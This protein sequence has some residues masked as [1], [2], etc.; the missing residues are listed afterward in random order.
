MYPIKFLKGVFRLLAG[1]LAVRQQAASTGRSTCQAACCTALAALA[2]TA[3]LFCAQPINAAETVTDYWPSLNIEGHLGPIRA[4]TFTH[5][6]NYL[7]TGGGHL[8]QVWKLP[9]QPGQLAHYTTL[10]WEKA[11]DEWGNVYALAAK[12][13]EKSGAPLIAIAGHSYRSEMDAIAWFEIRQNGAKE[14]RGLQ[15]G[16]L[17]RHPEA[18]NGAKDPFEAVNSLACDPEGR[19]LVSLNRWGTAKVWNAAPVGNSMQAAKTISLR[20]P[21]ESASP[22]YHVAAARNSFVG[23]RLYRKNWLLQVHHLDAPKQDYSLGLEAQAVPRCIAIS[24]D[25]VY[26]AAGSFLPHEQKRGSVLVWQRGQTKPAHLALPQ[27]PQP[28]AMCFNRAGDMLVVGYQT[29]DGKGLFAA[30]HNENGPWTLQWSVATAA[31]VTACAL[32]PSDH[33]LALAIGDYEFELRDLRAPQAALDTRH[34]GQPATTAVAFSGNPGEYKARFHAEGGATW[35]FDPAPAADPKQPP[36]LNKLEGNGQF[37]L[38]SALQLDTTQLSAGRLTLAAGAAHF[39]VVPW[40][41]EYGRPTCACPMGGANLVAI[42]TAEKNRI[43]IFR[44]ASAN[45]AFVEARRFAGHENSVTSVDASADGKFLVSSSLDGTIRYWSLVHINSDNPHMQRWGAR[46]D[47]AAGAVL[48]SQVELSGPLAK[49]NVTPKSTIRSIE[50]MGDQAGRL[51]SNPQQILAAL[52][53][54]AKRSFIFRFETIDAAGKAVVPFYIRSDWPSILAV[55]QHSANPNAPEWIAWTHFGYFT[56]SPNGDQLLGWQLNYVEPESQPTFHLGSEL[57]E[58]YFQPALI[59]EWFLAAKEPIQVI[60]P[61]ARPV[62]EPAPVAKLAK[63]LVNKVR[64]TIK[65]LNPGVFAGVKDQRVALKWQLEGFDAPVEEAKLYV[66]DVN[67]EGSRGVSVDFEPAQRNFQQEFPLP[68]PGN[69]IVSAAVKVDGIW[70]DSDD[71]GDVWTVAVK[72]ESFPT[73][74]VRAIGCSRYHNR[75][76]APLVHSAEEVK[77]VVAQLA[78]RAAG[79][80]KL[81]Q[82]S[83]KQPAE[84]APW[85]SVE[86]LGFHIRQELDNLKADLNDANKDDVALLLLS[87]HGVVQDGEFWFVPSD[88]EPG[89]PATWIS[90][91]EILNRILPDKKANTAMPRIFIVLDTCNA[92]KIKD[93]LKFTKDAR[94]QT[95]ANRLTVLTAARAG[96]AAPGKSKLA[97][98]L[99]DSI[100]AKTTTF[101]NTDKDYVNKEELVFDALRASPSEIG[102]IGSAADDY[103][104]SLVRVATSG[105]N[106][107]P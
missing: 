81:P 20:D 82:P 5:D 4:L 41:P 32:S 60:D 84:N 45:G 91:A 31:P 54:D 101:A 59:R 9:Q 79:L 6:S 30:W 40:R 58:K 14:H 27:N 74:H 24:Q 100:S 68:G 13:D 49:W 104:V 22:H 85:A 77:D 99:I 3:A 89:K 76:F 33:Y 11:N 78:V 1:M 25:G 73:M 36:T 64:P 105:T 12:G 26:V 35:E 2:G 53:D 66:R 93:A 103:R 87:G 67:Q 8:V 19:W 16:V 28:R 95:F 44:R 97:A 34:T 102:R 90:G 7:C 55:R 38:R 57:F 80:Y 98:A 21:A 92:G 39:G 86:W 37:A 42:G 70:K 56:G 71:A 62:V 47:M 96:Q 106:I 48:A 46:L 65:L 52:R 29:A 10:R 69:Y 23:T 15:R 63:S 50:W 75:A 88:G 43:L 107:T 17:K 72:G 18:P 61:T 51:E 83:F 94:I